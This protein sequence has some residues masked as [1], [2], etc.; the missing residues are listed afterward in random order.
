MRVQRLAI[1]EVALIQPRRFADVRGFFS[2]TFKADAFAD[3]IGATVFVQDNEAQSHAAGTVRGLHFQRPPA[4][5]GKLVRVT[6][7]AVLDAVVDVRTG[8][9]SFGAVVSVRLDAEDGAQLWVPPGFA[10]GY[11][12]LLADT[13]VAYKVTSPYSPADEG[14]LL[15]SDPAL[16]VPWPVSPDKAIVSDKDRALPTLAAMPPAFGYEPD[17][18]PR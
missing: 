3:A 4:A 5:Q 18:A 11:C 2:E 17:H 13:V 1:P 14:G 9:P 16:A 7:G 10:H 15:W 8:S 12:T 6:R